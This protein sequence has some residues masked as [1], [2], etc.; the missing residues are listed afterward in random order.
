MS[1]KDITGQRFGSLTA[2]RLDH[3]DEKSR[4]AYWLYKCDCGKETVLRANTVTYV[5][6]QYKDT[7]PQFPSC[8]CLE[9]AQKTKHGYRQAKNTHPC[10]RAWHGI[11][12]RCY[13]PNCPEYKWYGAKGVTMCDEWKDN[14]KAFCDWALSH[15]WYPGAHIDKD[16]LCEQKGIHP[17]IYSPETCQWVDAKTNV[18]FS[19]NR[20]NYGKHPNVRL[21][22][23]QVAEI[24]KLHEE[25]P[26]MTAK[27]IASKYN[28]RSTSSIY[29]IY[30]LGH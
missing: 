2:I 8:G 15:G 19:A 6:K 13:N 21:S 18:G 28:I 9:L 5:A 25:N 20:D 24:L 17:H 11:K 3:V 7:K 27:E 12:D 10:Y 29:R 4:T 16:I 23:E 26:N 1:V 14:P 30:A 22:H